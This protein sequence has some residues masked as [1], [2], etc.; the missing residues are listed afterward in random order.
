MLKSSFAG[1]RSRSFLPRANIESRE[2]EPSADLIGRDS[3]LCRVYSARLCSALNKPK[4]E[5]YSPQAESG[6]VAST[7]RARARARKC[8][9]TDVVNI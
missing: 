7:S 9:Y 8:D 5:L 6:L 2:I 1:R 3:I 4:L